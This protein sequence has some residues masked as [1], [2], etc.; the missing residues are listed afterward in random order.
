MVG[1]G[2]N[3]VVFVE[4]LLEFGDDEEVFMFY[5]VVFDG[6]GNIFIV[7]FF[8]VVICRKR[9]LVLRLF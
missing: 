5:E 4:G 2:F 8:V 9:L 6:V 7:F 3:F 1:D